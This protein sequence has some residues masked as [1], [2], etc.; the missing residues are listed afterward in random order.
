VA[1][2]L[3]LMEALDEAEVRGVVDGG[4]VSA[5]LGNNRFTDLDGVGVGSCFSA[6]YCLYA[7]VYMMAS[8]KVDG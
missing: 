2:G 7:L 3:P 4:I 8:S 1:G 5:D 6:S